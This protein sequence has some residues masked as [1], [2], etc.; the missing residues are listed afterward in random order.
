MA[1]CAFILC[2]CCPVCRYGLCDGLIPLSRSPTDCVKDQETEKTA[3][4]L[5][6]AVYPYIDRAT[7]RIT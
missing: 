7:E 1:V 2:L 5:Q 6:R 3:K 4:A